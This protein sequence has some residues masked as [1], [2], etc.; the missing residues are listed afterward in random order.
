M[1]NKLSKGKLGNEMYNRF[2]EVPTYFWESARP[3]AN[4]EL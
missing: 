2:Y 3:C 4:T 1:I